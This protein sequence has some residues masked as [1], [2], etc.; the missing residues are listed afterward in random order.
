VQKVGNGA[1]GG[2]TTRRRLAACPTSPY[3]A[4]GDS[5]RMSCA[6]LRGLDQYYERTLRITVPSFPRSSGVDRV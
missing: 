2:L 6:D 5:S 3:A 4:Q 1:T